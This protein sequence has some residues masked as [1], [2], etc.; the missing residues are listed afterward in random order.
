M[1]LPHLRGI[2]ANALDDDDLLA[3][4][5]WLAT[6]GRRLPPIYAESYVVLCRAALATFREDD[7][8]SSLD[9]QLLDAY[10]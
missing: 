4:F 1:L 6:V 5:R 8:G 2:D 9:D 7:G 3:L 10:L